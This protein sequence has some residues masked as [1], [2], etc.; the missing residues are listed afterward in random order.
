MYF[1][2]EYD[3]T[4]GKWIYKV[5]FML[6]NQSNGEIVMIEQKFHYFR[7]Q[8]YVI[9]DSPAVVIGGEGELTPEIKTR[10]QEIF[11]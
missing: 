7:Q 2:D 3:I 4:A 6:E 9:E 1:V 10:L 8:L 11:Q 5:W